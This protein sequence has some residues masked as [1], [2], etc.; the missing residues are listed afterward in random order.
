MGNQTSNIP[1]HR[2]SYY[3]V[4]YLNGSGIADNAEENL[5]NFSA[6][7]LVESIPNFSKNSK[8]NSLSLGNLNKISEPITRPNQQNNVTVSKMV[9]PNNNNEDNM[10][11]TTNN[12]MSLVRSGGVLIQRNK[13]YAKPENQVLPSEVSMNKLRPTNQLKVDGKKTTWRSGEV[14]RKRQT[15][16]K[17]GNSNFNDRDLIKPSLIKSLI[18][19]SKNRT[20]KDI[21]KEPDATSNDECSDFSEK[22]ESINEIQ[23]ADKQIKY[24]TQSMH[25]IQQWCFDEGVP[26]S[27]IDLRDEIFT[28]LGISCKILHL[29]SDK[30]VSKKTT[31]ETHLKRP[32]SLK[33][34]NEKSKNFDPQNFKSMSLSVQKT[35]DKNFSLKTVCNDEK[36]MKKKLKSKSF[37]TQLKS[38]EKEKKSKSMKLVDK[39][40]SMSRHSQPIQSDNDIKIISRFPIDSKVYR[41]YI[42]GKTGLDKL[43][44]SVSLANMVKNEM[45]TKSKSLIEE[46]NEEIITYSHNER[47]I[48]VVEIEAKKPSD[49]V[50]DSIEECDSAK[51]NK[52]QVKIEEKSINTSPSR[53]LSSSNSIDTPSS[54]SSISNNVEYYFK[55]EETEVDKVDK[56]Q[57]LP[58]TKSEDTANSSDSPSANSSGRTTASSVLLSSPSQKR[59]MFVSSINI[60]YNPTERKNSGYELLSDA[61]S[62][63]IKPSQNFL[64]SKI[65]VAP[66]VEEEP[67][68]KKKVLTDQ[69]RLNE[70]FQDE[71][72]KAYEERIR[73]FNQIKKALHSTHEQSSDRFLN[74]LQIHQ[75]QKNL[76]NKRE[77]LIKKAR[78]HYLEDNLPRF[79]LRPQQNPSSKHLKTFISNNLNLIFFK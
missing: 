7:S 39:I 6:S 44:N 79:Y 18:V 34:I 47:A 37:L 43:A 27:S 40:R 57:N 31:T 25:D 11:N 15:E 1:Q 74:V 32:D 50:Y 65:T 77:D 12:L 78:N 63:D 3:S 58:E 23:T 49:P 16:I 67:K 48:D 42:S 76:E 73:R 24:Q 59:T 2:Q 60:S 62:R 69:K 26:K 70:I 20:G 66:K 71:I 17:I 35:E 46:A 38:N 56:V 29:D 14:S 53:S 13:P 55:N 72:Q 68:P 10:V 41:H 21:T 51:G 33:D 28:E 22:S 45:K 36:K 4:E 30:V 9:L 19:Q 54:T 5:T 52:N 8:K 75:I 64:V 61:S